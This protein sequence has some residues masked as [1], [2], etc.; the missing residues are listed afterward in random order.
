MPSD[1]PDEWST[2]REKI[3]GL[4]E[5]SIKKSYYPE[6][7]EHLNELERFRTL[8]DQTN[9]AIFLVE[10]SSFLLTD[11]NQSAYKQ[12]GYSAKELIKTS[13]IDIVAPEDRQKFINI[14]S[15]PEHPISKEKLKFKAFFI[16]KDNELMPMEVSTRMVYFSGILYSVMV[17]RDIRDRIAAEKALKESEDYY[18]TIFENTGS[19]TV[20]LEKDTIIS[21]VNTG[22]E[23]LTG[24]SREEIEGKKSFKDFLHPEELSKTLKYHQMRRNKIEL[25]PKEYETIGF[26]KN[27]DLKYVVATI[28]IIPG[29]DKSLVSLMDITA[30]KTAEE[31][32]IKS[33][34]EKDVLLKE[35]HHRVKNNL[36]IISSLLNLQSYH[37]KDPKDLEIFK[38]SQIRVKSMALIH[39]QLYQSENLASINFA[40]YIKNITSQLFNS[41]SSPASN[42]TLNLDLQDVNLEIETAIPCGLIINELVSNSLKHA[43]KNRN[44]GK[45]SISLNQDSENVVLSISDDGVGFDLE[46]MNISDSL[47]LKLVKTLVKQLD[48]SLEIKSNEGSSFLISFNE[49]VYKV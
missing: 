17:A 48:G 35:I 25:A 32:I 27:G 36:Q 33:L 46:K 10:V 8:L 47:G 23:T 29:T 24:Y 26:N 22:F 37:I 49:A 21:R 31:Q 40:E 44:K 42:I 43:F 20:I 14:F 19:A 30:R 7:Q 38:E 18:R 45:I 16:K 15:S 39:E 28:A 13:I 3:I 6:L 34:E 12:L 2:L 1:I 9:D 11:L 4:G 5:K 41:Y